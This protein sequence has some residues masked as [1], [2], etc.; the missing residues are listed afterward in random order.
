MLIAKATASNTANIDWALPIGFRK[1]RIVSPNALPAT[2]GAGLLVRVS[3]D[4][5]SNYATSSYASIA[6]LAQV[7]GN[8]HADYAASGG[9]NI[10]G[11]PGNA[12]GEGSSFVANIFGTEAGKTPY[13]L[14]TVLIRATSGVVHMFN[15]VADY[16]GNTDRVTHIRLIYTSGN[17]ASGDFYLYGEH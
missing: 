16:T 12:A 8:T 15:S 7:G 13:M 11:G 4:G 17:I 6:F 1:F 2:D 14:A 9:F 3:T 5:G 10:D